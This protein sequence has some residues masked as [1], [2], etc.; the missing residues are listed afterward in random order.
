MARKVK[1]GSPLFTNPFYTKCPLA[2][3]VAFKRRAGC[4]V[5]LASG[6]VA[7][8]DS[9]TT[10]I[11]GWADVGKD[12][13]TSATAG[14]DDVTVCTDP[15]RVWEVPARDTFTAA[16][17]KAYRGDICDL[18]IST[19]QY[20]DNGEANEGVVVVVGG[21]VDEQTLFVHMNPLKCFQTTI[22]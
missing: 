1:L 18:E 13:T 17:L 19:L 7:L 9:G 16:N 10:Q 12:W 15:Y 3:S 6:N 22:V 8:A 2:A 5:Y 20:V 21:D 11:F 4:F 14:A